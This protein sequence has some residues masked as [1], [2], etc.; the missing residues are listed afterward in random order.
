MSAIISFVPALHKGYI[1]F[2]KKYPDTLYLLD[3]DFVR[4]FPRLERDLRQTNAEEMKKA[5]KALNIFKEIKVL[6]VNDVANLKIEEEIVMPDED[7]SRELKDKYFADKEV[8]F[9]QIFLRWNRVITLSENVVPPDRIISVEEFDNEMIKEATKEAARSSDWWRQVGAVAVK[10]GKIIFAGYNR[11]MPSDLTMDVYGDPRS[12]FDAGEYI[13][14]SSAIHGEANLIA[15]AARKG[16]SL[17]GTSFYVTTFP[18][19]NC[20]KLIAEAGVK[21]VYYSKGYSLVDA[22]T[23]LKTADI[24]IV[25]VKSE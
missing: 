7:I 17:E 24:E 10:D 19:P 22:E 13:E 3:S 23:I 15:R 18:C 2:F 8:K 1:D 25:L 14:L 11:H 16:I 5:I 6:H 9:E 20:A 12:S 4:D 21:K